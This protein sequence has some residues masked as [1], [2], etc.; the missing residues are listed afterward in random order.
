MRLRVTNRAGSTGLAR[1]ELSLDVNKSEMTRNKPDGEGP[2]D[3]VNAFVEAALTL[4]SF[5]AAD[6]PSVPRADPLRIVASTYRRGTLP[7]FCGAHG[8]TLGATRLLRATDSSR[9]G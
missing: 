6:P 3:T 8:G 1:Q 2:P 4:S 9:V 5:T 7:G